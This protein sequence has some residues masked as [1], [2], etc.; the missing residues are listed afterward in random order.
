MWGLHSEMHFEYFVASFLHLIQAYSMV[1]SE[2]IPY[3]LY[4]V[5]HYRCVCQFVVVSECEVCKP[6]DYIVH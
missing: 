2:I 4:C 1:V 5:V 6:V 3:L